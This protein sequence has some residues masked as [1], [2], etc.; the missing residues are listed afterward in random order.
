MSKYKRI[1]VQ[2]RNR[3]SLVAAL[4]ACGV[5]FDMTS[6]ENGLD[7]YGFYGDLRRERATFVVRR[8]HIE[9]VANDLGFAYNAQTGS[10]EAIIS[11]FD[12]RSN[13]R[14]GLQILNRIK[15]GYA[16]NE[17]IR[18]ARLRGYS[19]NRVKAEGGAVRLQLVRR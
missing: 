18:Q 14:R 10:Y 4:Q 12:S 2:F 8:L 19:V 6:A 16:E 11:E 13:N 9:A 15:Q 17:V 3:E 1:E 5:P 7:L